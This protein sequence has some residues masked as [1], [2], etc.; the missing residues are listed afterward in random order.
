M[1]R[2]NF[3]RQWIWFP[4]WIV[5]LSPW[6]CAVRWLCSWSLAGI[7]R[8]WRRWLLHM[9]VATLYK[10]LIRKRRTHS[11]ITTSCVRYIK[12]T[13]LQL[14]ILHRTPHRSRLWNWVCL[15]SDPM[16]GQDY[17][18]HSLWLRWLLWWGMYNISLDCRN[19]FKCRRTESFSFGTTWC[20]SISS[21]Q[22]IPIWILL[23]KSF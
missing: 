2:V 17:W 1:F 7:E 23:K 18:M 19:Y 21:W 14:A 22:W 4:L 16:Q 5:N 13:R 9:R 20:T 11:I 15:D 6:N 12:R 8:M 3:R 10:L